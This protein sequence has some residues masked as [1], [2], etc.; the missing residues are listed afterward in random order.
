MIMLKEIAGEISGMFAADLRLSLA[1]L[2]IVALAAALVAVPGL[3]PLIGGG[4]LLVGCSLV[5]V[6]SVARSSRGRGAR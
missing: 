4:V 2:G 1:I 5:L 3:D 6:T